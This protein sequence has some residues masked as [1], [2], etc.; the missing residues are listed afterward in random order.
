MIFLSKNNNSILQNI[1]FKNYSFRCHIEIGKYENENIKIIE[2]KANSPN[3]TH[4]DG[5]PH[6]QSMLHKITDRALGLD[7]NFA[8]FHFSSHT[9]DSAEELCVVSLHS[10]FPPF[11]INHRRL[12]KQYRMLASVPS[13]I[14]KRAVSLTVGFLESLLIF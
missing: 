7:A 9:S 13:M 2:T 3:S 1:T 5:Y 14:S 12:I 6:V 4:M 11:S 8:F 10:T